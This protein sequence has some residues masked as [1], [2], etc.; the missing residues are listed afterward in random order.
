[1]T[2]PISERSTPL[3]AYRERFPGQRREFELFPDRVKI[4]G[5]SEGN[6]F[7]MT[8]PLGQLDSEFGFTTVR[9]L[10]PVLGIVSFVL[11]GILLAGVVWGGAPVTSLAFGIPAAIFTGVIG[12][13]LYYVP[14]VRVFRFLNVSGINVLDVFE[15]GPDKAQ[16]EDFARSIAKVIR[17]HRAMTP[18]PPPGA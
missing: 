13:I 14:R 1:M 15:S 10:R 12:L 11:S 9:P 7:E 4:R 6:P 18:A 17:A 8:V 2:P 16:A 5:K 3:A